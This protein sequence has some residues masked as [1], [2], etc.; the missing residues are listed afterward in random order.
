M[1]LAEETVR[2]LKAIERTGKQEEN[3]IIAFLEVGR[4]GW[5]IDHIRM[6]GT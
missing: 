3:Q 2:L 6:G 4:K 1:A 5:E